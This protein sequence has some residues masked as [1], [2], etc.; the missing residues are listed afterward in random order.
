MV[1]ANGNP[2]YASDLNPVFSSGAAPVPSGVGLTSGLDGQKDRPNGFSIFRFRTKNL[3]Q[4]ST[5]YKVRFTC[6]DNFDI[7]SVGL[8]LT[9]SEPVKSSTG[10]ALF[11]T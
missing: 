8:S 4:S 2:I 7:Y 11:L 5:P 1:I 3:P 6:P 9:F 10:V